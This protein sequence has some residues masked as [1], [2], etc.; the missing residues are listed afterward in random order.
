MNLTPSWTT[1]CCLRGCDGVEE[2]KWGRQA[3]LKNL[4]TKACC[5]VELI[6]QSLEVQ[7]IRRRRTKLSPILAKTP[8]LSIVRCTESSAATETPSPAAIQS[9]SVI[10]LCSGIS[11]YSAFC[12]TDLKSDKESSKLLCFCK[13]VWTGKHSESV[14]SLYCCPQTPTFSYMVQIC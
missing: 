8:S 10:L 14:H 9:I 4:V 1:L 7:E 3:G 13:N 12:P 11:H 2:P 6:L 5:V